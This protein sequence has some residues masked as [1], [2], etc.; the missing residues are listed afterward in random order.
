MVCKWVTDF[1][2]TAIINEKFSRHEMV[3]PGWDFSFQKQIL[4]LV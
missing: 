1:R 3:M 2:K 4:N